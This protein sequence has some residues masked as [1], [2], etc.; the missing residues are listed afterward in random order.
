MAGKVNT[1]TFSEGVEVSQ[2]VQT[3]LA[4]TQYVTY[5]D[6]AAYV[7]GKGSAAADGDAYYNTTDDVIRLYANGAWVTVVD[8]SDA[9]NATL[10][11]TQTFTGAKTFSAAV[12]ISDS[13]GSTSKDT[14]SLVTEGGMGVEENLYVGGNVDVT[15]NLNV[16][17]TIASVD[18]LEVTD[19]TITINKGGNQATADSNDAGTIVE[20]SDATDAT[21]HYDSTAT[22][23][24]K[25]G[26]VGSTVEIATISDTQQI[27]NKDIDGGTASNSLRMT[28]PKNTTANLDALTRKEGTLVYDTSLKKPK[29]DDGTSLLDIGGGA[30]GINYIDNP[31]AEGG[32]TGWS[33]FDDAG[34]YVDGTGGTAANLTF[35]QNTTTP[36]RGN[37][38]FD[39]VV[40]AA[41]A[42][43]EGVSYDF[44]IDK[45]DKYTMLSVTFDYTTDAPDDFFN[46]IVYDVTN[47]KI[48]YVVPES[49]D[50]TSVEGKF[51]GQFQTS[52]ST[53]YRL[54]VYVKDTDATGY[55]I[56]F[57]NVVVGPQQKIVGT[58]VTDWED[59]TATVSFSG[60]FTQGN[61]TIS[62]KE[63]RVG[64]CKEYQIYFK[65]GSTS[66]F[67]GNLRWTLPTSDVLDLNKIA[68]SYQI[69]GTTLF[70]DNSTATSYQGLAFRNAG[71]TTYVE[72][73]VGDVNNRLTNSVPVTM[74][75][76]DE[77][78]GT[79]KVPI[80]G[81]GSNVTM[82]NIDSGRNIFAA[83]A[84][85]GGGSVTQ[86]VTDIDFTETYDSHAAWSGTTFTLPESGDYLI[87]GNCIFTTLGSRF[88]GLYVDGVFKHS[89]G[90]RSLAAEDI[91]TFSGV[92]VGGIKG[93]VLSVREMSGGVSTLSNST[94][95]HNITI[96]KLNTGKNLLASEVVACKYT[97]DAGAGFSS[98][99]YGI[100]NFEDL[101]YDTHNAYS[102][103][104]FTAPIS[105]KYRMSAMVTWAPSGSWTAG[106]PYYTTFYKNT[107]EHVWEKSY[108]IQSSDAGNIV[109]S[110]TGEAEFDLAKGETLDFRIAQ[111][112][113]STLFL[114]A[115]SRRN[116]ICISSIG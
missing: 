89:L 47:S 80:A 37:A 10:S 55:T 88:A 19:S 46:V 39:L 100:V 4:T 34:S 52:D 98:G 70:Y 17:G 59:S 76:N 69:I 5:A 99:S 28:L 94:T 91:I 67:G 53:S 106:V 31:D 105:K 12:T 115:V 58:P 62:A 64:D 25:C 45:A 21:V 92:Y 27:T 63:R 11:G 60:G 48:I 22:S 79:F 78:W 14:G 18:D 74:A 35:T 83:G 112:S 110:V 50:A 73:S 8:S 29:Y 44:T 90:S 85:N 54:S 30:G 114:Q 72:A 26:E 42:S 49:V 84:G 108:E 86:L 15:G 13:T 95:L 101:V 116:V 81:L 93:Q 107:T 1:L 38:D 32:I 75:V 20:M 41:D 33:T 24:W 2:P 113:G 103:G 51:F 109:F 68:D 61:G 3:F 6:D 36:L 87:T 97:T 56:N 111:T 43:G 77:M 82:S 40:G 104:V 9:D 16:Q 7:T 23:K 66:V 96:N 102:S 57:D 71:A 65:V